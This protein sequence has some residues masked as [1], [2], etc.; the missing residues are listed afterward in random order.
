M[1]SNL[2]NPNSQK[3]DGCFGAATQLMTSSCYGQMM[4]FT[5]QSAGAVPGSLR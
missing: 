4:L 3:C 2:P 5:R 1:R